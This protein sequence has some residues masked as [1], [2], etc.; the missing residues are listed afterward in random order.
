MKN[1][2]IVQPTY[3]NPVKG[4]LGVIKDGFFIPQSEISGMIEKCW[5]YS[6]VIE[7]QKNV[8]LYVGDKNENGLGDKVRYTWMNIAGLTQNGE[9]NEIISSQNTSVNYL[10]VTNLITT[11]NVRY[12]V[13]DVMITDA[14]GFKSEIVYRCNFNTEQMLRINERRY[15]KPMYQHSNFGRY[16][17]PDY[18]FKCNEERKENITGVVASSNNQ[19]E[20][21]QGKDDKCIHTKS[22]RGVLR[23]N[24]DNV[25]G[26]CGNF[27]VSFWINFDELPTEYGDKQYIFKEISD[28]DESVAFE[29]YF[30]KNA[31]DTGDEKYIRLV[32]AYYDANYSYRSDLNNLGRYRGYTYKKF[33]TASNRSGESNY[34]STNTWYHIVMYCDM[35]Q[36]SRMYFYRNSNSVWYD[37][38]SYYFT[39]YFFRNGNGMLYVCNDENTNTGL[40]GKIDEIYIWK[41]KDFT[42]ET[43]RQNFVNWLYSSGLYWREKYSIVFPEVLT[44]Y[45][46]EYYN[47][48]RSNL[49]KTD[50]EIFESESLSGFLNTKSDYYYY[51]SY[52][53]N[54][55]YY[56]YM[57][58]NGKLYYFRGNEPQNLI[59]LTNMTGWT[60]VTKNWSN[61]NVYCVVFA[62]CRGRLYRLYKDQTP[63]LVDEVRNQWT[64]IEGRVE[65]TNPASYSY[66]NW[67]YGICG[68]RLYKL[69]YDGNGYDNST[70]TIGYDISIIGQ[71]TDW[72]KVSGTDSYQY[73]TNQYYG[74]HVIAEDGLYYVCGDL[75]YKVSDGRWQDVQGFSQETA[76]SSSEVMYRTKAFGIDSE[77]QLMALCYRY[78]LPVGVGGICNDLGSFVRVG[79]SDYYYLYFIVDNNLIS[80]RFYYENG[81]YSA[82][83]TVVDEGGWSKVI[84]WSYRGDYRTGFGIKNGKLYRLIENKIYK[85]NNFTYRNLIRINDYKIYAIKEV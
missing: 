49:V 33:Y 43:Y 2:I 83:P 3:Q 9:C 34:L 32:C 42:N 77:G 47:Y 78:A 56:Y 64:D 23:Y 39:N 85:M 27:L 10:D 4:G 82:H 45:I 18:V 55:D 30:E 66:K 16:Y 29:C 67:I 35:R 46:G 11:S 68:G 48:G 6:T 65:S 51:S 71:K 72:I 14:S 7:G 62:I 24:L 1:K 44:K 25:F 59:L 5:Y 31:E 58:I 20:Y 80:C 73:Y 36:D 52:S 74:T 57:V 79:T 69:I 70:N 84:C 53:E 81:S 75:E 8:K 26:G 63:V 37:S 12:Y 13:A 28:D 54:S 38:S 15:V 50:S 76:S 19:I 61:N 21:V 40:K 60:K 17:G 41:N 22:E